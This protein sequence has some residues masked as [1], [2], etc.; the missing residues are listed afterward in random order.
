MFSISN[1]L[2]YYPNLYF[3]S[4]K[5]NNESSFQEIVDLKYS[6]SK[7]TIIEKDFWNIVVLGEKARFFFYSKIFFKKN[8]TDVISILPLEIIYIITNILLE[9]VLI[10]LFLAMIFI[11][12]QFLILRKYLKEFT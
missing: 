9:I 4:K 6:I 12:S 7:K 10:T 3:F 11:T 1:N 2:F 5:I 8:E